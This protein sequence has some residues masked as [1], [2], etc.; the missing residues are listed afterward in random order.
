[1]EEMREARAQAQAKQQQIDNMP[2]IADGM[3]KAS[4][5][6]GEAA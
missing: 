4:Q 5:M 6:E 3:Y 1:V 2:A